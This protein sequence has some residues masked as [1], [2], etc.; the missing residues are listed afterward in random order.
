M[1]EIDTSWHEVKGYSKL[2][3]EII[4]LNL[5]RLLAHFHSSEIITALA[6]QDTGS[7]FEGLLDDFEEE[8][9]QTLLLSVAV[10]IRILDDVYSKSEGQSTKDWDIDVGKF[11][12]NK[13]EKDFVRLSL[14]EAC[15]KIVHATL[16]NFCRTNE[17]NDAADRFPLVPTIVLYGEL[18]GVFWRA[19]LNI[20]GFVHA[21]DAVARLIS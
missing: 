18:R 4:R 14:R 12:P 19:E 5:Y 3:S 9:I 16:V 11:F 1:K 21:A 15:N 10:R 6:N 2:G 17:D 8:E 13:A 20:N 7:N